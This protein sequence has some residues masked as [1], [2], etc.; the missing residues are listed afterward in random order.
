MTESA[1]GGLAA[2]SRASTEG[3]KTLRAGFIPLVDASV[4][5]AAAE[6]GFAGRKA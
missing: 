1:T 5:I 3:P 6:F 2:P 4:L